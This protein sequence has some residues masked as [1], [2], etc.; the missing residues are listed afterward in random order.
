MESGLYR[1]GA[2]VE[3][4]GSFLN[5]HYSAKLLVTKYE[6]NA[7]VQMHADEPFEM[8]IR[9]RLNKAEDGTKISITIVSIS[10]VEFNSPIAI[11]SKSIKESIEEDLI[12]LKKHLENEKE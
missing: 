11:V 6:E 10:Q 9:Y 3:R 7:F 1:K 4:I 12:R 8:S 2:Q 5:K